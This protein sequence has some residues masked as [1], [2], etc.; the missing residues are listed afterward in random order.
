MLDDL[1]EEW[2][3]AGAR[4]ELISRT[5][6]E[7]N[8]LVPDIPEF[9]KVREQLAAGGDVKWDRDIRPIVEKM[10]TQSNA[11]LDDAA[12]SGNISDITTNDTAGIATYLTVLRKVDESANLEASR[13]VSDAAKSVKEMSMI[14]RIR[15]FAEQMGTDQV[16]AV[17][18]P[19]VIAKYNAM[20]DFGKTVNDSSFVDGIKTGTQ[21]ERVKEI[22]RT[23][24]D[25]WFENMTMVEDTVSRGTMFEAAYERQMAVEM[26]RYRNPD[27]SDYTINGEPNTRNIYSCKTLRI[28]RNKTNS[29][30]VSRQNTFRR[31]SY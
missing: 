18:N 22:I 12:V 4:M 11:L 7:A 23:V 29:L 25:N 26:Q 3:D 10:E 13:A 14:A 31:N 16:R 17:D 28:S 5:R 20:I 6:Y 2:R 21:I 19:D 8:S 24:T 27:G 30:R 9:A 15:D 1:P